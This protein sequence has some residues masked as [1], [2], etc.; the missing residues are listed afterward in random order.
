MAT[1]LALILTVVTVLVF[2]VLSLY[3]SYRGQ[4]SAGISL[5][6]ME[7]CER[8]IKNGFEN[9]LVDFRVKSDSGETF[10]L[11]INGLATELKLQ[12]EATNEL[13]E[14]YRGSLNEPTGEQYNGLIRYAQDS[15]ELLVNFDILHEIVHYWFDVGEGEKVSRSFARLHHGNTRGYREQI[16]DYYVA[17]VA[18]P[19][20]DLMKRL[21]EYT[22][23]PYD[24]EFVTSLI[25]VYRLPKD[26]ITRRISEVLELA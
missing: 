7:R 23:D 4:S 16:I 1:L 24:N 15:D 9:F 22:G 2:F 11:D 3:F 12:L 17:A 18:I 10:Y 25:S 26:T 21:R 8:R 20:M 5:A 14:Q 13:P 19:K 6:Q